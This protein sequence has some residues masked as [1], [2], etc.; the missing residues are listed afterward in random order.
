LKAIQQGGSAKQ[1]RNRQNQAILPLR[2]K[3]LN[4]WKSRQDKILGSTEIGTLITA[5]GAGIGN[6]EFDVSKLRYHKVVIMT[7][8]DVDGSHI[9]TLLLTFFF[10]EMPELIKQGYLYIARPPLY[11]ISKNKEE[12]YIMD[13]DELFEALIEYGIKDYTF[14]SFDKKIFDAKK[15]QSLLI[16]I[17]NTQDLLKKIPDRY[18]PKTIEQIA[19]AQGLDIKNFNDDKKIAQVRCR[20]YCQKFRLYI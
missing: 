9:R 11:K 12:H 20:L 15:L 16:K 5:L 8:A 1:G 17:K 7:D 6:Q 18:D 4:T 2:G 3:I 19:I 14:E 10:K 13:D